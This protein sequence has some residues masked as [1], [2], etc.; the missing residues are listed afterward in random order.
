MSS[1]RDWRPGFEQQTAR[2]NVTDHH[3]RAFRARC[4]DDG[5]HVSDALGRLVRAALAG[6]HHP[7]V[8]QAAEPETMTRERVNPPPSTTARTATVT[9]TDAE[10]DGGPVALSLFEIDQ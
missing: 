1:P 9:P 4:L 3:W 6:H 5:E 10:P 8:D 7:S 2:I